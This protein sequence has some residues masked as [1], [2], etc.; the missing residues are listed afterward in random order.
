MSSDEPNTPLRVLLWSPRGSGTHYYGPGSFFYRMYSTAP[1][2]RFDITLAHG[3]PDHKQ[4]DLFSRQVHI[5]T[6]AHGGNLMTGYMALRRFNNS[7]RRFLDAHHSEFDVFHGLTGFESIVTP[8]FHAERLGLPAVIFLANL[9]FDLAD[10]KGLRGMLGVARRRR[11]RARQL[12]AMVAMS[13]AMYDELIEYGFEPQ[14]IAR[15]PMG[16]NMQRFTPVE[17]QARR[18]ALRRQLG[19]P[20][21]PSVVFVGNI[22][23]RK[24]PHLLVEAMGQLKRRGVDCQL[25]LVGPTPDESYEQKMHDQA[26]RDGV[27]DRVH[28]VGF[29]EDPVPYLQA[30]DLHSLPS[31][32][33]G[34]PAAVVEAMACA[35]PSLSTDVSGIRDVIDE[36]ENGRIIEPDAKHIADCIAEYLSNEALRAEHGRCARRRVESRYSTEFVLSAYEKLFRT[37][38]AGKP[39]ADW[40][41]YG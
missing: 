6:L 31:S 17:D 8:A 39:A 25:L 24:R 26:K 19:I 7:A 36:G 5:G 11:Q 13:R 18:T 12:S 38:I 23:L 41:Q 34:M 29:V 2:G 32:N 1:A 20:D 37:V 27:T 21:R 33:E 30:A 9:H 35:L 14:R 28:Y 15:I 10:K 16:V 3:V 4:I 40:E 22:G